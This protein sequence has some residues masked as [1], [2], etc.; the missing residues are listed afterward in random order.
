MS[1]SEHFSDEIIPPLTDSDRAALQHA[2]TVVSDSTII[3][4][5]D[6]SSNGP[7][8]LQNSLR[9]QIIQGCQHLR[10]YTASVDRLM[11]LYH[12]AVASNASSTTSDNV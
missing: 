7:E 1:F 5:T 6:E 3:D 4:I 11:G 10:S 2:K 12:E 8:F 9:L